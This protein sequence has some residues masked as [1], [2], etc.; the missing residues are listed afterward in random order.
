MPLIGRTITVSSRDPAV[1]V[2]A[3]QVEALELAVADP[4]LEDQRRRVSVSNR[5]T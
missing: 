1:G 3:Q 2:E 5:S 4:G